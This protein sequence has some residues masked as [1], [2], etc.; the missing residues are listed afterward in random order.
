MKKIIF[1][2]HSA[3]RKG[4]P[5]DPN[6]GI[7]FG[8][9]NHYLK[10]DGYSA[11]RHSIIKGGESRI[12]KNG[13][14]DS[15]FKIPFL[16]SLPDSIRYVGE[17]ISTF[18]FLLLNKPITVIAIDP[19]SCLVPS[20]LWKIGYIK[21]CFFITPDFAIQRFN[22]K[23]LNKIYFAID[24][25]CTFNSDKNIV[26]S[27]TVIEYKQKI[28][29]APKD[30]FFH[31]PNI[32]NPWIIENF[33]NIPKIKNRII[34]VGNISNQI[35][36]LEIFDAF[37]KVK[38]KFPN[39]SLVIVGGGRM[40]EKLRRIVEE[41]GL[42]DLFFLGQLS[43]EQTLLEIAKSEIGIA[44]YNG[45][46]N[47]DEFRDSCKIREYQALNVI[48]ITTK[49]VKANAEE[50]TKYQSGL[51]LRDDD[52]F[53]EILSF[54][55]DKKGHTFKINMQNNNSIYNTKYLD[56]FKLITK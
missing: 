1:I 47:Y 40:E 42:K 35:N 44:I 31:M 16:G 11:I 10:K 52:D 24:R 21:K 9:L 29:N 36:F 38:V 7:T 51:I 46:F 27:K 12:Y 20:L 56:F 19:L 17:L 39:L 23:I 18:L 22:N 37:E 41:R 48:P 28:Y 13:G 25:F 43:Y 4:N 50:I 45:S 2:C 32:P 5:F 34:Y 53:S 49:I 33:L 54:I 15:Y 26:C 30:L 3:Y 55:I 14:E 6:F 8:F